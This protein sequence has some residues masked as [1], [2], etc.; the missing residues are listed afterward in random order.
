MPQIGGLTQ[1]RFASYTRHVFEPR[2]T[3]FHSST[4]GLFM[5]VARDPEYVL[6]TLPEGGTFLL[7]EV[8]G[9]VLEIGELAKSIFD[10]CASP[11]DISSCCEAVYPQFSPSHVE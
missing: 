4:W 10:L 11:I 3:R 9:K 2:V 7:D 1:N 6:V 8:T 5:L